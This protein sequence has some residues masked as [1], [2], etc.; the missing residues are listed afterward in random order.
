MWALLPVKLLDHTKLRL[1]G[2][3]TR[4]QRRQLSYCMVEDILD[5]LDQTSVVSGITVISCDDAVFSLAQDYQ[6]EVLNTGVDNGYAADVLKGVEAV[7]DQDIDKVLII[8]ADVPELDHSDL[9]HLDRVHEEGLAL[10]PPEK[11]GGTN[12]L[13]FTPPLA[14]SLMYGEDSF[15]EFCRAAEGRQVPVNIVTAGGLARD[16]D[17][18]DDLLTLQAQPEGNRTWRY[19]RSLELADS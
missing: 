2:I 16:I 8:P 14:V 10:C 9:I 7:S 5:T 19:L 11:H 12:G 17:R 4:A 18:P 6:A 13:V 1:A 3:L 15:A